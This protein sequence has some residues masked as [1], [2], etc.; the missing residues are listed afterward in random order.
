M[1]K[2]IEVNSQDD[3]EKCLDIRTKVF[4]EEQNVPL[5]LEMDGYD[6]DA[7]HLL[8][9]YENIPCATLRVLF[10]SEDTAHVGRVCVLKEYRRHHLGTALMT[11]LEKILKES[12]IKHVELG[13]QYY[14]KCFY[15]KLG[16]KCDGDIFMDANI[17]HI[18]M[19][20]DID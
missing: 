4:I 14:I 11:Y 12:K 15:E 16:Y 3:F 1:I 19:K 18:M 2:I 17:E 5:E 20:K 8:L 7:L 13:A 9:F 6:C 10:P